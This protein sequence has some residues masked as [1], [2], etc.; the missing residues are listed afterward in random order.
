[1]LKNHIFPKTLSRYLAATYT[2]AFFQLLA[3]LLGII[4]LFDT[5]ELLRRAAK[6]DTVPLSLVLQMGLLKLPEVGQVILPFAVLFSALYTFWL[7]ARRGELVVLRAAGLSVWQFLAPIV[8]VAVLLGFVHMMVINPLGALMIARYQVLEARYLQAQ[9]NAVSI[10]EQGL[11]LRQ[12]TETGGAVFHAAKVR[13]PEWSLNDVTVF[14]FS[15]EGGFLRRFDAKT[16]ILQN[17]QWIFSEVTINEPDMAT[18]T[19]PQRT[20]ETTLTITKIEDSFST[21]EQT[22]FWSLPGYIRTMEATGFDSRKLK[23]HYQSLL[24][25]PLLLAAMVILAA[26]VSMKIGRFQRTAI[27]IAGGMA[28]GFIIFFAS[29]FLQALG[30]A[31]QIPAILAAWVPPL[32]A[33]SL[34]ISV[35]LTTEDG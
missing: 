16:A 3:V 10:S 22:P 25:Q 5:V 35:I 14:F 12:K 11:W 13:L 32:V 18:S 33:L 2:L 7:L 21:P 1:M 8:G 9:D 26:T 27:L 20:L 30:A 31:D 28:I 24:A 34:G 4:Y 17:G 29:S 6:F 19:A 15:G 23:I